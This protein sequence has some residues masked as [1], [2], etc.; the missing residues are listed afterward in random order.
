MRNNES[1]NNSYYGEE[2]LGKI[3]QHCSMYQQLVLQTEKS[4]PI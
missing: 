4:Q 2:K 3:F 1:L